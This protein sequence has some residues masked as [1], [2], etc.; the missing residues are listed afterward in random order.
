[1]AR[2]CRCEFGVS[3]LSQLQLIVLPPFRDRVDS[4]VEV[5][6]YSYVASMHEEAIHHNGQCFREVILRSL[7]PLTSHMLANE[8]DDTKSLSIICLVSDVTN[9]HS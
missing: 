1:M 5:K 7:R 6:R 3:N 9:T 8:E 2:L 4:P